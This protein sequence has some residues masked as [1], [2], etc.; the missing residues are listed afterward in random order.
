MS[1]IVSEILASAKRGSIC[2]LKDL[3][4]C[5]AKLS[6]K[7]HDLKQTLF[8]DLKKEYAD[9]DLLHEPSCELVVQVEDRMGEMKELKEK[10]ENAKAQLH[11][12]T[13]EYS[14]LK[15]QLDITKEILD[16]LDR[17]GD[18]HA[19]MKQA[20][21]LVKSRHLR[22]AAESLIK[23]DRLLQ[24]FLDDNEEIKVLSSVKMEITVLREEILY[25]AKK[26]WREAVV[27]NQTPNETTLK[28]ITDAETKT[29]LI[30]ALD[31]LAL[32]NQLE[33]HMKQFADQLSSL[34]LKPLF[35]FGKK[36]S[37]SADKPL[38]ACN[39][40]QANSAVNATLR[41]DCA[42]S[43]VFESLNSVSQLLGLLNGAIFVL[44]PTVVSCE[45]ASLAVLLRK[46]LTPTLLD[47]ALGALDKVLPQ[48]E[49]KRSSTSSNAVTPEAY[50]E[51]VAA[52]A[53]ALRSMEL[54]DEESDAR[55]GTYVNNLPKL[56]AA[57]QCQDAL[58]RARDLMTSNLLDSIDIEGGESP[59]FDKGGTTEASHTIMDLTAPSDMEASVLDALDSQRLQPILSSPFKMPKCRVS[60]CIYDLVDLAIQTYQAACL[61]E[62]VSTGVQLVFAVRRMFEL[63]LDVIPIYHAK[64]LEELPLAAALHHNNTMFIAHHITTFG[65]L[66]K[67][68]LP[69]DLK[70]AKGGPSAASFVDLVHPFKKMAAKDFLKTMNSLRAQLLE[71]LKGAKG[72]I[73]DPADSTIQDSERTV[74]QIQHQL[75][76][77][78]RT[79]RHVLPDNLYVKSMGLLVNFVVNDITSSILLLEDIG[80]EFAFQLHQLFGQLI[81]F[82]PRLLVAGDQF[83]EMESAAASS[84]SSSSSSLTPPPAVDNLFKLVPKW[85]RFTELHLVLNANLSEISDRWADGKGQLAAVFSAFEVKNVVRALFENNEKR[86]RVLKMIDSY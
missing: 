42:S 11:L 82:L 40:D 46:H 31:A 72:F 20:K 14:T 28:L 36:T 27:F 12:S 48:P 44:V 34:F 15:T 70:S 81:D 2:Q 41:H 21:S 65:I 74:C 78:S 33:A 50:S 22:Q 35:A 85:Q 76:Q 9:F 43:S 55:I 6:S 17:L 60:K 3:H 68:R 71:T 86:A 62:S 19:N 69:Q 23:T 24:I 67:G 30:D 52:F 79:W 57:K 56:C 77:L 58:V 61:S 66:F 39:H 25:E 53:D 16:M 49:A 13:Q 64:L 38:F 83:R 4:D 29:G 80:A 63:F 84:S 32:Y 37:Q 59:P 54:V 51:H 1:S 45:G 73:Y 8:W 47:D 75:S 26:L 10:V 18:F 5:S 7:C